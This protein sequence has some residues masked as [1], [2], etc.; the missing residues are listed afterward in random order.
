MTAAECPHGDLGPVIV[1]SIVHDGAMTLSPRC[2]VCNYREFVIRDADG[3]DVTDESVIF[4][5][6][7]TWADWRRRVGRVT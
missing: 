2:P 5:E 1:E 4:T 3:K 6:L 7:A